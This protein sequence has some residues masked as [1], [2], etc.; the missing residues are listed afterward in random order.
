MV[1][2]V[3]W[4]YLR[5]KSLETIKRQAN[6]EGGR[7]LILPSDVTEEA[8][9]LSSRTENLSSNNKDNAGNLN[10]QINREKNELTGKEQIVRILDTIICLIMNCKIY[11]TGR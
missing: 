8:G 5:G 1:E 4:H 11:L 6:R 10:N 7:I 9:G 3:N 2:I